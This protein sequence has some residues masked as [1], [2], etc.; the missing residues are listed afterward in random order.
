MKFRD[1]VRGVALRHG[2][3]ASF[4]PKPFPEQI[5]S[6]AHI[7]F[8]LWDS[9]GGRNLLYAPDADRG[10]SQLGRHF[11]AGVAEHLP[12]LVALTVPS[13]NS[14]RRLTP[15][16]WASATTA[17]GFDNKEA[18]LRVVSPFYG[19]EEQSYNIE[20]KTS[21]A[22]ANPYL[23]LGALIACGLD[24]VER[25]LEPGLPCERDPAR[26]APDRLAEHKV[27]PLPATMSAAL[28]ELE[29]D[30]FLLATMPDLLQRCYLAVRRSEAAAFA[31]HD[32]DFEIRHHFYRF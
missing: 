27:R 12:A 19:R 6:G 32:L 7:H 30:A 25:R 11:I 29:K 28:D 31:A 15:Q 1:T 8:S 10:L 3:L 22:S 4:A 21:D 9:G 13:Y 16:A 20:F 5:G 26:L 18:A 24:G 14:Y 2:L 23:A 17:W